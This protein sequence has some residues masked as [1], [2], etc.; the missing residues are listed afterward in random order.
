MLNSFFPPALFFSTQEQKE[1]VLSAHFWDVHF[2]QAATTLK[3]LVL[4]QISAIL[5]ESPFWFGLCFCFSWSCMTMHSSTKDKITDCA[6]WRLKGL[7][8]G[9]AAVLLMDKK[10]DFCEL[11][12]HTK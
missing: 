8:H 2:V 10:G 1:F 7:V 4:P 12:L 11:N 5:G 6:P 3:V 9:G